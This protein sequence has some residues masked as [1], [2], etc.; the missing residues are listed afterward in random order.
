MAVFHFCYNLSV[1]QFFTMDLANQVGW[2]WFRYLI[3]FLFIGLVGV[4]LGLA[5]GRQ[6]R[7]L[8]LSDWMVK[9]LTGAL[10]VTVTTAFV[11]PGAWVYFGIL[12]A[13]ALS[14][15][16]TLPFVTRPKLA[17]FAGL[18]MILA[19]FIW[20]QW[21][22]MGW[23]HDWLAPILELPPATQDIAYLFPWLGVMLLGIWFGHHLPEAQLL[24]SFARPAWLQWL[25]RHALLAYLL[26]Q[27]PLYALAYGLYWW[28][29]I[30]A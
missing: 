10:L 24:P 7:W 21:L 28:V 23:L 11:F 3:V 16:L 2:R 8:A 12:H 22:R 9:V 27:I 15:I 14:A 1:F 13:I 29:N 20:P 5:H 17:L 30:V 25:G 19:T 6:L 4:G 18:M 26:H